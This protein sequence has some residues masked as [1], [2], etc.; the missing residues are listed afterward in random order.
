MLKITIQF[1]KLIQLYGLFYISPDFQINVAP[2]NYRFSGHDFR[3]NFTSAWDVVGQ[4]ATDLFTE[5]AVQLI[6]SHPPTKPLF[7]FLPHLAVHAGNDGKL[8]EA[9]QEEINRFSYISNPNRRTYAG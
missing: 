3:R 1:N 8:L 6:K 9:P 2:Y 7:L 5:Q 4:Y